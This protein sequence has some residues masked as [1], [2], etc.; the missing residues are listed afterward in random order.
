MAGR[1]LKSVL[2]YSLLFGVMGLAL[3]GYEI[4]RIISKPMVIEITTPITIVVDRNTTAASFVQMLQ[5]KHLIKSSRLF[6]T[7]IRFQG[8]TQRL[9]AGIYEIKP[10]ETAQQ[11]LFQ[12]E[13][14]KVMVRSFRIIEGTNLNQVITNLQNAQYLKYNNNDWQ[15]ISANHSN[16]EGLLLADT[17]NYDAGSEAKPLLRLAN[18]KLQEYLE[19]SWQNRSPGLPYKSSYEMLVAASILEKEA[20]LPEERKIISG[21]IINRLKKNMPLQMDPTVIYAL[22]QNYTGKLSHQDMSVSSPYNTYVN[23]GLPPTP[24]AM[25]GKEAIDAAAHPQISNYLY[26]VAKGDGSHQFSTTYD[27]QKAAIARYQNKRPL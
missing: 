15:S 4:Y 5:S 19:Q 7:L 6:L 10:G 2:L 23:R 20:A 13:A 18:Q 17:Y 26:F 11:L 3:I 16:A 27:E 22:G 25:V 1:R 8:L 21:V 14:G 24:I 12:V 9:K